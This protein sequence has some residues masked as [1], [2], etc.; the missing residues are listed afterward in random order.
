MMLDRAERVGRRLVALA[1]GGAA[2]VA[3]PGIV[4]SATDRGRSVGRP[5]L[6]FSPTRLAAVSVGWFGAAAFAWR[7]LPWR[8]RPL[9]RW[10]LLGSGFGAFAAGLALAVS[11]RLAL[12]SSYRPSATV[13]ASLATEHR[14]VTDGPYGLM[15]HPM[16]LG[17][18]LMALGSLAI[19]RTW[20]TAWFVAQLPV[21]VVRARRE[22][23]LLEEAIGERWRQYASRVPAWLPD[24]VA[25]ANR[26][27]FGPQLRA[28]WP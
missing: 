25:Q 24:V 20:T 12:G 26:R 18:T 8:P 10:L 14:V 21:L 7:P 13:G 9:T 23:V 22:E 28:G 27:R 11:G 5:E 19:Y 16:Y 17:L 15:R 4:A 6:I 2:V 1:A 3:V